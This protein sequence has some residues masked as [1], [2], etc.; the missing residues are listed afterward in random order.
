MR[1]DSDWRGVG[2]RGFALKAFYKLWGQIP[3]TGAVPVGGKDA[4][5]R[6]RDVSQDGWGAFYD[7]WVVFY[8]ESDVIYG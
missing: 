6:E 2:R 3:R 5:G 4:H 1:R 7:G 8:D